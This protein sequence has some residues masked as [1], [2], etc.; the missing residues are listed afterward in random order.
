MNPYSHI[1]LSNSPHIEPPDCRI[2][3]VNDKYLYLEC[4][5]IG[6]LGRRWHFFVTLHGELYE[7]DSNVG[8]KDQP[9]LHGKAR[10]RK[11]ALAGEEWPAQVNHPFNLDDHATP[12]GLEA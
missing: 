11:I 9:E 7:F 1:P 2:G 4:L 6:T 12:Q 8:Y 3:E 10:Y 5:N